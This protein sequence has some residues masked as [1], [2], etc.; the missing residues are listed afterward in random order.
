MHYSLNSHKDVPWCQTIP[1]MLYTENNYTVCMILQKI[2]RY[3][4]SHRIII[5]TVF[6]RLKPLLLAV[7]GI[8]N[9]KRLNLGKPKNSL[10]ELCVGRYFDKHLI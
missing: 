5:S 7:T 2:T 8:L 4:R 1:D 10:P 6:L 9:F 3:L